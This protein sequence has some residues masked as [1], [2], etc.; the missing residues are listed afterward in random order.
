MSDETLICRICFEEED[1]DNIFLSPCSCNGYSKYI[2]K[3]CLNKW[4]NMNRN[5]EAWEK[6]MECQTKYILRYKY[7][8][9]NEMLCYKLNG[10]LVTVAIQYVSVV[11]FGGMIYLIESSVDN[12]STVR[13][14]NLNKKLKTPN[15]LS[16]IEKNTSL[17]P[18]IFYFAYTIFIQTNFLY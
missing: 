13:M 11:F 3:S 8:L 17:I 7:P 6:C 15:L 18:C 5:S 4:R 12:Y 2:H 16:Y 1:E 10:M 9:E 14:L